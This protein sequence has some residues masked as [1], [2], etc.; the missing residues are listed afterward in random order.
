M[1][2]KLDYIILKDRRLI[3][4]YYRG[5]YNVNELI[6]FKIKVGNDPDYDPNFDVVHDFRDLIFDLEIEEVSKYIQV[7]TENEKYVGRRRSTMITQTPNQVT[8]SLGFEL[9]KKELPISVKVCST[10]EVALAYIKIPR[11]EWDEIA[12]LLLDLQNSL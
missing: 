6:D 8:A 2:P 9:L 5:T 4:E 10:I 12:S 11:K 7:L 1:K 3:I